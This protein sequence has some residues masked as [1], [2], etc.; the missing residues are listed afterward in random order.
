MRSLA[1]TLA[2]LMAACQPAVIDLTMELATPADIA[3]PFGNIGELRAATVSLAAVGGGTL[4][5]DG[6]ETGLFELGDQLI[7]LGAPE[8][9]SLSLVGLPG[10]YSRLVLAPNPIGVVD[11]SGAEVDAGL[12][13]LGTVDLDGDPANGQEV[14][15]EVELPSER[16][17][18]DV[19]LAAG[20]I[21]AER[22]QSVALG[23]LFSPGVL[24]QSV[25]FSTL[26]VIDGTVII[27]EA[28][29]AAALDVVAAN[30]RGGFTLEAR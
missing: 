11:A 27:N 16:A 14:A 6:E 26:A 17:V 25:D 21:T 10:D 12:S 22:G 4:I 5:I 7:A 24:F 13:L 2:L 1:I 20:V 8:P 29:N 3:V 28:N 9:S 19:S 15:L 18:V 30:L 23:L